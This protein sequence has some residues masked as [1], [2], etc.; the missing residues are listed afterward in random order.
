MLKT[1]KIGIE[2]VVRDHAGMVI[3]CLSSSMPIK[4][5]HL[6]AKYYVLWRALKFGLELGFS[7]CEVQLEGDAQLLI[8]AINKVE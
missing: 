6:V 5:H 2:I 3:G 8:N 1:S 7:D 4:P